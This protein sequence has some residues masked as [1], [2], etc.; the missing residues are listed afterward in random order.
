MP[1]PFPGMDPFL[2]H[3]AF[4]SGVHSS[5]ISYLREYLQPRLP[6][7]Y[8]AEIADR[9]WVEVAQRSIEPD[10]N[11]LRST[12]R[13]PEDA[14]GGAV[15]ALAPGAPAQP[16]VVRVPHDER[17]ETSLDIFTRVGE[18][19]RLVTTI[20]VLSLANKTPGEHGRD[21]YLRKQ[22]EI[23]EG[24]VHLVE[25]DLLRDGRHTTA[26]P[27]ERAREQAG[28]FDYHVCIHR[29]DNLEDYFVYP[30]LLTERLPVFEVPLLPGDPAVAVDLQAVFDRCYDT[31][32]YRRRVP[33][34][35]NATVPPLAPAQ[36][37]WATQRLREA[38]LLPAGGGS[39]DAGPGGGA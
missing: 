34:R 26:V 7:P 14:A 9:V 32:S 21:L 20:E 6:E 13:P 27:L 1:S 5:M 4:F 11:L 15:V 38:G 3:P 31:G 35:Q 23:L 17:R 37:V 33:Y 29:F 36:A 10:V 28:A 2:E 22:R 12:R 8:Y 18:G 30:V 39:T 25:I 24:K 19:E 16:V